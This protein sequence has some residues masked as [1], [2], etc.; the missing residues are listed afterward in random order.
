M[1][2][3]FTPFHDSDEEVMF[4]KIS[5]LNISWPKNIDKITRDLISRILVG[6]PSMR[7]TISEIKQH[8]FFQDINWT[9]AA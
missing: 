2:G 9:E 6:D 5:N 3:G 1:I 8:P 7:L 4:Q